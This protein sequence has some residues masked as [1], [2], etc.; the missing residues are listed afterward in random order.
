[1][2]AYIL[3]F[4]SSLRSLKVVLISKTSEIYNLCHLNSVIEFLEAYYRKRL[5]KHYITENKIKIL[6]Q[7]RELRYSTL[8]IY[9]LTF[10][11]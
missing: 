9:T 11:M 10:L 2:Y 6:F 3:R 4:L 1:M 8:V 5:Q 7:K